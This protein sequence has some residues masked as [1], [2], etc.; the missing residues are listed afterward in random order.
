MCGNGSNPVRIPAQS[1]CA[2]EVQGRLKSS[3][4]KPDLLV[5]PGSGFGLGEALEKHEVSFSVLLCAF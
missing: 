4:P 2:A 3:C 5:V 1:L